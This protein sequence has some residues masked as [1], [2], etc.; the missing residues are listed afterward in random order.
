MSIYGPKIQLPSISLPKLRIPKV[1]TKKA[2]PMVMIVALI[3]LIILLF[4]MADIDFNSHI[5]VNWKNNPLDLKSNESQYAELDLVLVNTSED[6]ISM[7]LDV[8]SESNEI[9]IFCP[10]NEFPNV[11]AGNNRKTTCVVRRNPNEKVFSGNYTIDIKTNLG[12]AQTLLEIKT[13]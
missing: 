10:D 8:T 6:M 2:M 12:V 1:N 7:T 13:K 11:S 3:I 4:M 9:I 5:K